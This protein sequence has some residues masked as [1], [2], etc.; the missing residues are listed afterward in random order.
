MDGKFDNVSPECYRISIGFNDGTGLIRDFQNRRTRDAVWE[1]LDIAEM[2]RTGK[3]VIVDDGDNMVM[4]SPDNIKYIRMS[5]VDPRDAR[6]GKTRFT[7]Q[8]T[9]EC[10]YTSDVSRFVKE[11]LHGAMDYGSAETNVDGCCW[12]DELRDDGLGRN[13]EDDEASFMDDRSANLLYAV[14]YLQFA[15]DSESAL[16]LLDLYL[17]NEGRDD[18]MARRL[19]NIIAC[20]A[21]SRGS[22]S[23]DIDRDPDELE[24][25]DYDVETSY[26]SGAESNRMPYRVIIKMVSGRCLAKD[27]DSE[28]YARSWLDHYNLLRMRKNMDGTL[29]Y[30]CDDGFHYFDINPENVDYITVGPKPRFDEFLKEFSEILE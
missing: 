26:E 14:K 25:P 20:T 3:A 24:T 2:R 12:D 10:R 16:R 18:G 6:C 13:T 9:K 22:V 11:P 30:L 1:D 17:C 5:T 28:E 29:G 21:G 19:R 23:T 7:G 4:L 15:G 27:F 8:E